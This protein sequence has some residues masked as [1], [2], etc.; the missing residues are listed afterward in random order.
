MKFPKK[1]KD[2]K[3]IESKNSEKGEQTQFQ[4]DVY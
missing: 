3:I 1:K 2:S 4:F